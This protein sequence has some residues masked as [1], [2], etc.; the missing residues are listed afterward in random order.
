MIKFPHLFSPLQIRSVTIPNRIL[1]TGHDTDLGR[2]GLPGEELIAYQRARAKGGAGLII[3]QVVGVHDTARYTSEVLMGTSDDCIPH[4][5]RLFHS[6]KAEG[7]RAFVQLFHPGRELLSRRNGV[8]QP[9]YSASWSPTERFRIVPR[10]LAMDEVSEIVE[11]YGATARRMAEAGADGVEVV[12]SHGYLP[13]QFLSPTV[14]HREDKYGGSFE[15]RLRFMRD[16]VA[17]VRRQAPSELIVGTRISSNDY[18]ADGFTDADTVS[19]C[20]ALGSDFDYFNVIAGT[21]AS[22]SGAVHIAPPMT[23][24]NAYLAPFAR[25]LKQTISKPVFVAGRINQPQDA[26]KIIAQGAA[27]MCGMTRAMICDPKMPLKA[28]EGRTEDIRACIA[29]NQAC[30]GHA[31]LGLSI[32]CIQYPE[33]GR[34]LAF[35]TRPHTRN[36]RRVMVVGGGPAGMKAAAVAAE[37]GH[38]VTLYESSKRLGGQ[39]HLAQLLPHRSEFGGL[40]TNLS[41]ELELS[42]AAVRLN[43]SVT[44]DVIAAAR[45]DVVIIATGSVPQMPRFEQGGGNH[46]VLAE[47]VISGETKTGGRVVIYDWLADW[48][49]VGV[50]EKLASEGVHVRLAVNGVCAA[51]SIQN[52]VRDSAIA[53]L[54]RFGVETL[55]FMR[56]YGA[57][58]TTVYFLHTASQ[59]SVVLED[60]DTL[61]VAAANRPVDELAASVR[62]LG[63]EV[64]LIGDALTPR[65]AEEAVFEGLNIATQLDSRQSAGG[66]HE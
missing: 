51:A 6:I 46:A 39:V 28:R 42:G 26:E 22:S 33:S 60:V 40:V 8:A 53:C 47:Q 14:N 7:T 27:D 52:Y 11:C 10:A 35:G 56:L 2:H 4:F 18:D 64:H 31:Q 66:T 59:E 21:S 58:G 12:A 13:A 57:E 16:I 61:V 20:S 24:E 25:R 15:N 32:S 49:G 29:C 36:P 44:A 54:H 23:V 9:A 37:I 41:R 62:K 1:S 34:E 45:P 43:C 55:P 63:I 65:T 5:K 19:I 30:I 48:I 17:S 38:E 3:V 50:A